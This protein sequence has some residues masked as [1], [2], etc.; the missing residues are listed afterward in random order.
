MYLLCLCKQVTIQLDHDAISNVLISTFDGHEVWRSVLFLDKCCCKSGIGQLCFFPVDNTAKADPVLDCLRVTLVN[1][2]R[3]E[4]YVKRMVPYSWL[5]ALDKLRDTGCHSMQL[6]EVTKLSIQCRVPLQDVP[7]RL[8][9][10]HELGLLMHHQE[11]ALR[12]VVI[13]NPAEFLVKPASCIICKHRYHE[14]PVHQKAKQYLS[15]H[16][17]QLC[18]KGI[19][20]QQ[21]L[22][23]LWED[24]REYQQDLEL[25]MVRYGLM[26]S[27]LKDGQD[28][29][30]G[31]NSLQYLVPAVLPRGNSRLIM[32]GTASAPK[33]RT[34]ILFARSEVIH[35]W[36]QQGYVSAGEVT[37]DGFLPGGLF[38]QVLLPSAFQLLYSVSHGVL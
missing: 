6:S 28:S 10:F 20:D 33:A 22:H 7:L 32:N 25:L 31:S 38:A 18:L 17:G 12:R 16:Y 36:K 5:A 9:L 15:R 2:I 26:V 4:K 21:L 23:H 37:N 3:E 24:F 19:L 13:L 1:A 35:L 14:L 34:V 8:R 27:V 30:R 11:P 29:T